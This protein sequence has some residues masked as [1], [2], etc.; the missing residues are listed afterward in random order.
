MS[1]ILSISLDKSIVLG[2]ESLAGIRQLSY[3]ENFDQ[4]LI[5]LISTKADKLKSEY[6]FGNVHIYPVN[7]LFKPYAILKALDLAKDL[8]EK[9][10]FDIISAQDPLATGLI[11]AICKRLLNIPI[12][13]QL[14]STYHYLPGWEKESWAN[15]F[16]KQLIDPVLKRA[17]SLRTVNR[18]ILPILK[19]KYAEK[20]SKIVHIPVMVDL[21]FYCQ[22]IKYNNNLLKFIT[23]GRLI[24]AKNHELL[25]RAFAKIKRLKPEAKL[26][27]IGDGPLKKDIKYAVKA[28]DL[29]STVTFIGNASAKEVKKQLHQSDI[30]VSSS[31]YEGWGNAIIEAMSA[32]LPVVATKVGCLADDW[33][34]KE[35]AKTVDIENENHLYEAMLWCMLNPESAKTMAARAQDAV[36]QKLDSKTLESQWIE[37]LQKTI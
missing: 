28:L 8:H 30:Y 12:N 16:W 29:G 4:Y 11:A 13:I 31:D 1:K 34:G 3:A 37:L 21:G 7:V 18:Q 15:T 36:L 9:Y 10:H 23:V 32:G 20:T 2:K 26:T 24:E 6:H 22:K 35:I 17:D 14:H 19:N 27:I 5:I 25:L 33:L